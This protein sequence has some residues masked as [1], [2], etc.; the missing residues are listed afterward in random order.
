MKIS[1]V[2]YKHPKRGYAN[3]DQ[4]GGFGS[5]MHS[6]GFIGKLIEKI[7]RD[8]IRVPVIT[9][10]YV[11]AIAK[12]TNNNCYVSSEF[13]EKSDLILI[14]SSMINWEFEVN[15]AKKIRE[16]YKDSKIGFFGPFASEYPE[17]F[18]SVSDFILIGEPENAFQK[19]CVGSEK[20]E[21]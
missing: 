2:D 19:I 11:N 3:R 10:A 21:G 9:I 20:P 18:E 8:R 6:E 14:A 17:K 1:I 12:E 7:K 15:I 5:G 16:K 13:P 4:T